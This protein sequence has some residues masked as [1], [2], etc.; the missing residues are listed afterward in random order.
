MDLEEQEIIHNMK[1]K[2]LVEQGF[3]CAA[4]GVK[5]TMNDKMELAHILP[6]RKDLIKSY[7]KEI[8]HHE[9]N[10]M[11]THSG[12]CNSAV[13]MSPNKTALVIAHIEMIKGAIENE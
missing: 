1:M 5:F 10:M 8:M 13:Q 2:K 6:Q 7:G 4:C 11:L 12:G 9:L 3:K